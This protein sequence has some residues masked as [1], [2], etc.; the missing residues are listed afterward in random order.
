MKSY[1]LF[2]ILKRGLFTYDFTKCTPFS[3]FT[4]AVFTNYFA[5]LKR[6]YTKLNKHQE[7]V[8]GELMKMDTHGN[9][10]LEQML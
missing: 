9:V 1:S 3:Y 4:R 6:Y 10:H 7:Y 5:T 8:K 2:R